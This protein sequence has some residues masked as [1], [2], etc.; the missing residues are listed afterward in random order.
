MKNRNVS[1]LGAE[2]HIEFKHIAEDPFLEKSDGYVDRTTKKSLSVK[3]NMIVRL[4][5]SRLFRTKLFG[6]KSFMHILRNPVFL[7]MWKIP[8]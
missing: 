3:K 2:Y 6:M 5:T 8:R 4:K 7:L 1:I